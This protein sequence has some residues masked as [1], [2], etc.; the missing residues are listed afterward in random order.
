M[1]DRLKTIADAL[2]WALGRISDRGDYWEKASDLLRLERSE[3]TVNEPVAEVGPG[4]SL[5][6]VGAK[7]IAQ[8]LARHPG[9]RI[10]TKLYGESELQVAEEC[11]WQRGKAA[12]LKEGRDPYEGAREDLLDWKRRALEA[13][14]VNRHFVRALNDDNGP[15]FMGEPAPPKGK[16]S[17][18]AKV[19]KS[20]DGMKSIVFLVYDTLRTGDLLY[21]SPEAAARAQQAP[22]AVESQAIGAEGQWVSV[23]DRLPNDWKDVLFLRGKKMA[24]GST[25]QLSAAFGEGPRTWFFGGKRADNNPPTHWMTL[26][27]APDTAAT[28]AG[29]EQAPANYSSGQI[30]RQITGEGA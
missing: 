30:T 1:S 17:A 25:Q 5:V 16:L 24:V 11:A 12:G 14:E 27:A 6:W 7:P 18:V 21:A 29:E 23:E 20:P 26:P 3:A 22:Q 13:E 2:E 8:I 4:F 15:T 28:P 9:V 10:G 19:V